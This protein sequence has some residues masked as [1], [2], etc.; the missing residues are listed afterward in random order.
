M[1][2][3]DLGTLK[4]DPPVMPKLRSGK[5]NEPTQVV[6]FDVNN[7]YIDAVPELLGIDI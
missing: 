2:P 4:A 6:S 5:T 7:P 1:V 3:I